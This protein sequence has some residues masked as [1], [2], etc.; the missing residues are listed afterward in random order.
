MDTL[1]VAIVR[2]GTAVDVE[3]RAL[4]AE[5]GTTAYD[6]RL[7]LAAGVPAVV[8]T[9][10]D[11]ARANGLAR[12]IVARG[13]AVH[14]MRT[15]DVVAA[16]AMIAMRQFQLVAGGLASGAAQLPWTDVAVLVRATHRRVTETTSVTT[17]KKLAIGRAIATG[18]LAMSKKVKREVTTRS[19][20]IEQVLYLFRASGATP[21]LLREHGTLYNAL[22]TDLTPSALNN[23]A[24]AVARFRASAPHARFDERLVARK[25]S[26][27][28]VDLLAHLVGHQNRS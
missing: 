2:L 9:T 8:L 5:L 24:L 1:V 10:P 28:E 27:D 3:A 4:A 14:V 16:D 22:G 18:G 21:W 19:E 26:A 13:H 20:D 7:K 23:F 6:E 12:G 11:E 15:S 17:E 25:P